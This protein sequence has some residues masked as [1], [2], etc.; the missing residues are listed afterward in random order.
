MLNIIN[1]IGASKGFDR[2]SKVSS[3]RDTTIR[4]WIFEV[5]GDFAARGAPKPLSKKENWRKIRKVAKTPYL[6]PSRI[7]NIVV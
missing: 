4:L 5:S 1:S 3:S 2:D 6:D 7:C